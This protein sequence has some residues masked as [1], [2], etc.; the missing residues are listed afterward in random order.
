MIRLWC[1][2]FWDFMCAR[3]QSLWLSDQKWFWLVRFICVVYWSCL[4]IPVYIVVYAKMLEQLS[5]IMREKNILDL[6]VLHTSHVM[7]GARM[8]AELTVSDRVSL[9]WISHQVGLRI[10]LLTFL[11]F[12]LVSP[13]E[14]S[15]ICHDSFIPF[16]LQS[17]SR[18]Y[19]AVQWYHVY[20]NIRKGFSL[21]KMLEYERS[22]EIHVW[23]AIPDQTKY[24][25]E[26]N[27]DLYHQLSCRWDWKQ[28]MTW[29]F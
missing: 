12:S 8:I 17:P 20:S 28:S 9:T 1:L 4:N 2:G 5:H 27:Q 6:Q 14:Y 10:N 24:H 3:F 16:S 25:A 11:W 15:N 13:D 26:H 22:S 18:T 19:S 21:S 23:I 7:P 29:H